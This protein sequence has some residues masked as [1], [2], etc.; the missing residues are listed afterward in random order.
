MGVVWMLILP[1]SRPNH[2]FYKK[3]VF[4]IF[5]LISAV[6]TWTWL[7]LSSDLMEAKNT[8]AKPKKKHKG[9]ELLKKDFNKSCLATSKTP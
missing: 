7:F 3:I 5:F 8:P 1:A 6:L 2:T 9:V 4:R